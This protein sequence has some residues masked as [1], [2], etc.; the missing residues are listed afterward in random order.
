[1]PTVPTHAWRDFAHR[2]NI[3]GQARLLD[4]SIDPSESTGVSQH[5]AITVVTP[6]GTILQEEVNTDGYVPCPFD[7]TL[8]WFTY[9]DYS[10]ND[11]EFEEM[12]DALG[13]DGAHE[14]RVIRC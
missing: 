1:M 6:N 3:Q 11:V 4:E 9:G 5:W 10:P 14:L 12:V 7:V 2:H 13:D 8:S